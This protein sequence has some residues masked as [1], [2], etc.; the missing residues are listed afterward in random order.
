MVVGE[1]HAWAKKK[2]FFDAKNEVQ[3]NDLRKLLIT[4]L[5]EASFFRLVSIFLIEWMTVEWCLPPKLLP[6]CGSDAFVSPLQRYMA[7]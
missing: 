4:V 6:I 3:L 1:I 7:I 5:N 2:A